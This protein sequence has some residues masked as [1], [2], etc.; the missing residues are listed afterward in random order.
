MAAGREFFGHKPLA[1]QIAH[2]LRQHFTQGSKV[3][4]SLVVGVFGEWGSGKSNLLQL[5]HDDFNRQQQADNPLPV[6][7]VPFNPWRYEKEE[8]LLVPLIKNIQLEIEHHVRDH[9]DFWKKLKLLDK[10][11]TGARFMGVSA[12]AFLQAFKGKY[13]VAGADIEF[14]PEKFIQG[15]KDGMKP[16]E[17]PRSALDSL[18]SYY[19]EFEHRLRDYTAG[20]KAF[21]LLFLIDDLDRCLP[22]KAVEMLESIKLFLDVEGCAFVL[23]LD[24]E[25][26]ERGI[27]HRYRDYIFQGNGQRL[28]D[29]SRAQLPITGPEYLEKIIHLPFRLPQP[30]RVEIRQF[31]RNTYPELFSDQPIEAAMDGESGKATERMTGHRQSSPQAVDLLNLFVNH[32]PPV[33]RKQIR[34][35]ELVLLLLGM[36]KARNCEGRVKP[37]P[38]VKLTLLQLYA[39]ELYRFGRRRFR[40]F[41]QTMQE[42]AGQQEWGQ[43]NFGLNLE[44]RIRIPSVGES[45][46]SERQ[47]V[48]VRNYD[49]FYAPMIDALEMAAHNRSGFDP[50]TFIKTNPLPSED[51]QDLRIYFSFV[52]EATLL[53]EERKINQ[54]P[55]QDAFPENLLVATLPNPDEFLDLLFSTSEGSWQSAV[56]MPELLGKV[57]DDATFS[58]V[59]M[60]LQKPDFQPLSINP[61]WLKILMP[62][63]SL[64]QTQEVVRFTSSFHTLP[65]RLVL[66]NETVEDESFIAWIQLLAVMRD[67]QRR[68]VPRAIEA[69]RNWLTQIVEKQHWSVPQRAEAGRILSDLG[70]QRKGVTVRRVQ[71]FSHA[72]PDIDWQKIDGGTFRMGFDTNEQKLNGWD[73]DS[74][75]AQDVTLPAFHISRYPVTNAQY[76]CFI[77][78]GMYEN[79]AFW[80]QNLPKAA[81]QWLDKNKPMQSDYWDDDKWNLDNHPVVGVSWFEALA[82][83]AW[84]NSLLVEIKPEGMA[85]S[86]KI[87]LPTEAEWEYAARGVENWRYAWGNDTDAS[88]GNYNDTDLGRTSAVGLFPQGKAFGLH[89]MTGNVWEW[90]SSRNLKY[91]DWGGKKKDWDLLDA[92]GARIFRGGSWL[93]TSDYVRCAIRFRFHPYFRNLDLGFRVVLGE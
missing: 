64:G 60:R 68:L 10:L 6:I 57:L 21:R 67:T 12:L 30:S 22:E 23:A 1:G 32:I 76:R 52:D 5:V 28:D 36:A 62:L 2:R 20:E 16:E 47:Q 92:D 89:D 3:G 11:K 7:V 31:L 34:T 19:F 59:F 26:V 81:V 63:L 65:I 86:A 44:S 49:R 71:S 93:N 42:W 56:Q 51:V 50:F 39:P 79:R 27:I 70:D 83:S 82:Y 88:L 58:A 9:E 33:P 74:K 14:E 15:I 77:E 90:T 17:V 73:D 61:Q 85:H 55:V 54:A 46:L 37:L 24:D 35:A 8:H 84:L 48:E 38:L 18:E 91:A 78:A 80:E 66:D 40:G 41:M 43:K 75:P 53:E 29:K 45:E 4:A 87:R 25:V 13:T 72:I 69:A